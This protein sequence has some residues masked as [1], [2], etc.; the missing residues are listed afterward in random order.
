MIST[1]TQYPIS[2]CTG[3]CLSMTYPM[4]RPQSTSPQS[5]QQQTGVW[6]GEW[7]SYVRPDNQPGYSLTKCMTIVGLVAVYMAIMVLMLVNILIAMFSDTYSRIKVREDVIF[8]FQRLE[9]L[10]EMEESYLP[11][12]FSIFHFI[13]AKVRELPLTSCTL[14]PLT[15]NI[16]H[17]HHLSADNR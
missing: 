15:H 16:T 13:L 7:L 5:V 4:Q 2:R 11:P 14:D 9:L 12:P 1:I 6:Y 8:K 17:S 3:S 10:M